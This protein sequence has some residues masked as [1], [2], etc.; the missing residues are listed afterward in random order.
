LSEEAPEA[1][2]TAAVEPSSDSA[3]DEAAVDEVN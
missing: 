2:P 3:D 1:P